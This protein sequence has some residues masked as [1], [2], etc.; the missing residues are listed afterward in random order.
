ME[1][2]ELKIGKPYNSVIVQIVHKPIKNVHL[3]ANA[4]NII[5][6]SISDNMLHSLILEVYE[7]N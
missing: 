1:V 4:K 5:Q 2:Y 6:I 7:V 3:K